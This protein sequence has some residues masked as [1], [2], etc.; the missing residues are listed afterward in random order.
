MW[1][2]ACR[3]RGSEGFVTG[4]VI[5]RLLVFA[6]A[7]PIIAAVVAYL[8]GHRVAAIALNGVCPLLVL[9][10]A[11]L[12]IALTGPPSR[13]SAGGILFFAAQGLAFAASVR[14]IWLRSLNVALFWLMWTVNILSFATLFYLAFLFRIF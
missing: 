6:L 5:L 13:I 3:P 7:T 14:G 10:G 9:G 11:A 8:R 1:S 4:E 2:V 12:T